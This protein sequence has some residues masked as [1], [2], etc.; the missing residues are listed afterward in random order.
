MCYVEVS[1]YETFLPARVCIIK[2]GQCHDLLSVVIVILS[3]IDYHF[4]LSCIEFQLS[5]TPCICPR[6]LEI[7][8]KI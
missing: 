6:I 4:P 7:E 8:L 5:A 3:L 1:N 2:H